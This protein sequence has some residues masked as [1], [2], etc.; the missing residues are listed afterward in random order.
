ME[1]TGVIAEF[2]SILAFRH[3]H[4]GLFGKSDLF[5]VVRLRLKEGTDA[6]KLLPQVGYVEGK[7]S[8]KL[9]VSITIGVLK[10]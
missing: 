1:E 7:Y 5:F 4:S 6:S 9:L 3:S 10:Y 2:D 8:R